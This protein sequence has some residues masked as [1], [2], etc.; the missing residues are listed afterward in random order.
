MYFLD[1]L[2]THYFL[3]FRDTDVEVESAFTDPSNVMAFRIV[4]MD[5]MNMTVVSGV[6]FKEC[7]KSPVYLSDT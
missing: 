2:N 4:L 3:P 7:N 5:W 6:Q 1:K